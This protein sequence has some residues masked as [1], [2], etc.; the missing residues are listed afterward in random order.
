MMAIVDVEGGLGTRAERIFSHSS[1]FAAAVVIDLAR[2]F[3]HL[4]TFV[5]CALEMGEVFSESVA[6]Q[7]SSSPLSTEDHE[8]GNAEFGNDVPVEAPKTKLL[9]PLSD[10]ASATHLEHVGPAKS[11]I[12]RDRTRELLLEGVSFLGPAVGK[13]EIQKKTSEQRREVVGP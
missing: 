2:I 12:L 11:N 13:H 4:S 3:A 8:E 5:A 1:F 6:A 7:E 9:V 10:E